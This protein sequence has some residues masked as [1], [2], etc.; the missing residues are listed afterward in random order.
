MKRF[1]QLLFTLLLIS[2]VATKG[3]GVDDSIILNK[4]T[5]KIVFLVLRISKDSL[6]GENLIE[7]VSLIK[8][9]GKM[10][11]EMQ[12]KID[13]ENFLTLD[14]YEKNKLMRSI[15]IEHPLFKQVEYEDDDVLTSKSVELDKT[16]FFV[17]LQVN[18]D[19][20]RIRIWETLKNAPRK[21][22]STIEL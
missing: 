4:D 14:L 8:K 9:D 2:C 19:L 17:R 12:D 22:L 16:E 6:Q 1:Y 11:N 20:N 13:S 10:K 5:D 3:I 7:F 18:G 15:T 21:E